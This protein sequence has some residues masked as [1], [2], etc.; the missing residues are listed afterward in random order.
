MTVKHPNF[1]TMPLDDLWNLHT[2]ITSVLASKI[3]TQKL[4]IERRLAELG[5]RF[6]GSPEDIPQPRPYP[7]VLP[8]FRN[9]DVFSET[10]SGRGRQPRWVVE[11]LG[12]GSS[13]DECRIQ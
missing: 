2:E 6:G 10:W 13:L 9:P 12:S 8:K 7:P 11:L 5:R 1:E 4:E 3:E